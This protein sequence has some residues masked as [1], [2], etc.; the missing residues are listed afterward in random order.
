MSENPVKKSLG[1]HWLNDAGSLQAMCAAA[2][3]QAGD[4]VLEIGPG[5]GSL[6][7][8]L[9]AHG[10]KVLAL[11][12]DETLIPNLQQSFGADP[13]FSLQQADVRTYDLTKLPADYKIVANIPYYLTSYLLRLLA[14][15]L[16]KPAVAALLV[17]K[18]VARRVAASPG[19]MSIIAAAVQLNYEVSLGRE[20]PARLFSPPP[21]VDSQILVLKR[22]AQLLFPGVDAKK[23]LHLV[24]AGFS[25]PRKTLLNNLSNSLKLSREATEILIKKVN[26]DP[27]LRAQALS[28]EN[29]YELLR[30]A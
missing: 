5:R 24:K 2:E 16:H 23:F 3:V 28:L 10:A 13:N 22:R 12:F 18:E 14:D 19:S 11:E 15:T 7:E 6:T 30:A 4:A 27:S 21:K 29:W 9:L 17:Q 1:Q 25:Q 8:F 20:V 26:L